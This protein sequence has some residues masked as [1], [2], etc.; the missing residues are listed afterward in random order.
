MFMRA[1]YVHVCGMYKL[2]FVPTYN[3]QSLKN[4]RFLPRNIEDD[5]YICIL[6]YRCLGVI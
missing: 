4:S 2:Y 5:D 1:T 6:Y 3:L